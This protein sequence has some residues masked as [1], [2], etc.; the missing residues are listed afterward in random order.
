MID[1]SNF[2]LEMESFITFEYLMFEQ[3]EIR[4]VGYALVVVLSFLPKLITWPTI[5]SFFSPFTKFR[6]YVEQSKN[7]M[8]V[9]LRSV[10]G[11]ERR[12]EKDGCAGINIY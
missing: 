8:M 11:G 1:E 4:P 5:V 7:L 10:Y 2:W 3:N 9:V 12:K 6:V